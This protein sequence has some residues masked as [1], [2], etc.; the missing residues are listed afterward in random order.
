MVANDD[1]LEVVVVLGVFDH[2]HKIIS[3]DIVAADAVIDVPT[4]D[5][6]TV[7]S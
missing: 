6:I 3:V 1:I 2:S 4:N 7:F 5:I